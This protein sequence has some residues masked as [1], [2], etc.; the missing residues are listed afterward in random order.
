[1][2]PVDILVLESPDMKSKLPKTARGDSVSG[3]W[4]LKDIVDSFSYYLFYS[5]FS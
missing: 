5:S 3:L 4:I 1:M 2:K